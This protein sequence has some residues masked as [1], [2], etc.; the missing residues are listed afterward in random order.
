MYEAFF[1]LREKP[2]SLLPDPGF[3]FMSQKHQEALTLLEYG[4]LNQAGFIVLTGEIGSGKTTLMRYLL[5]RLDKDVT[6]GL[7]SHTHQ[8]LGDLTHW[9]CSAFDIRVPGDKRL[10]LHQAFIDFLIANYAKGKRVLL[11]VDEAQNLGVEKL[12]EL[13]L[14]SNINA[15]KDLVLQ[16]MLLGQPQ[17]RDLL[18]KPE[19]EQFA[20]R[21]AASYH[22]GR[23]DAQETESYIQHRIFVAGG[24][25]RI[26][27]SDA[28]HAVHHYSGGIPRVIN[29]ICDTVLV[30]AYGAGEKRVTGA[31]VDEFVSAHAAHLLVPIQRDDS[32]HPLPREPLSEEDTPDADRWTHDTPNTEFEAKP[33]HTANERAE[34][35]IKSR[36][37]PAISEFHFTP[38]PGPISRGVASATATPADLNHDSAAPSPRSRAPAGIDPMPSTASA[39]QTA[40]LDPSSPHALPP[41]GSGPGRHQPIRPNQRPATGDDAFFV[42]AGP[43]EP[44]RPRR[45]G[46]RLG[47][48]ASLLLLVLF[49]M[50]AVWYGGSSTSEDMRSTIVSAFTKPSQDSPPSDTA[51]IDTPDNDREPSIASSSAAPSAEQSDEPPETQPDPAQ[52]LDRRADGEPTT[53]VASA[54]DRDGVDAQ[55][56]AAAVDPMVPIGTDAEGAEARLPAVSLPPEQVPAPAAITGR[57]PVAAEADPTRLSQPAAS[58][59][60]APPQDGRLPDTNE[61]VEDPATSATP[62]ALAELEDRLE[63]LSLEIERTADDRLVANLGRTVQFPDGS[64]ELDTSATDTLRRIAEILKDRQD[65]RVHVVGHTDSTGRATVNQRLSERR[66]AIVAQF[67]A[68]GGVSPDRLTHEGRGQSEL[69]YDT[70]Q[71]QIQ[72]PWINRRIELK[73]TEDPT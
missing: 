16:L 26:F 6:V 34:Q 65:V 9:I 15:D 44:P 27:S 57:D 18:K 68:S 3:L 54:L 72:G 71:E 38:A 1:D 39:L 22:L 48:L 50:A 55:A 56:Q 67:L 8:S 66:A 13:R 60:A 45:A 47:I 31:A 62:P 4:L 53:D 29:L 73:L 24:K 17:L 23:L 46:R 61:L 19:L 69:K 21:I 37:G 35:V 2:F 12:E 10:E 43:T 51:P 11:I 36:E 58:P 14:L 70:R 63:A 52:G 33:E 25:Y 30:Y 20:Q 42:L 7:I 32:A 64:D 41:Q 28:C 49:V 59:E 40:A 5:D